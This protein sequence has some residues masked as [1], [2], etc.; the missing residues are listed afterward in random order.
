ML[1]R[2]VLA[3]LRG[4]PLIKA[5]G[6]PRQLGEPLF[7]TGAGRG[8]DPT[9]VYVSVGICRTMLRAFFAFKVAGLWAVTEVALG[10]TFRAHKMGDPKHAGTAWVRAGGGGECPDAEPN[11]R[12]IARHQHASEW[13]RRRGVE[14]GAWQLSGKTSMPHAAARVYMEGVFIPCICR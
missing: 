13:Y 9:D 12:P 4:P 3:F 10:P 1:A 8:N 11:A 6:T 5:T 7:I 14:I 2:G